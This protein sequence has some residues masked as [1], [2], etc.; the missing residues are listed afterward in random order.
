MRVTSIIS[1][2]A[3]SLLA[4]GA[5][6][7]G[8]RGWRKIYEEE[9]ISVSTR[10]EAGRDMPS[11]RGQ[12]KLKAPIL[13]LLAILLDDEHSKEWAKGADE[14]SI[15]R[16]LGPHEE[17]LYARS[18]QPWPVKDRD[19]VMQ[20]TVEVIEPGEA[21]RVH[22]VCLPGERPQVHNVV[23]METCETS[24]LLRAVDASSTQ[25]DYRVH[26]DPG[27]HLPDWIVRMASK[28]IPLDTLSA[29]AKQVERTRGK[30]RD[31][32]AQWAQ[33]N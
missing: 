31:A 4:T 11:M 6:A 5:L 19:L 22:L 3:L 26:A 25:I 20:R 16:K 7:E 10:E 1:V 14:T 29:L 21:Y 32:A 12:A 13:H 2:L 9:G 33:A 18:N 15:V 23:R 8:E 27:G 28:S 24:F 17:I 30:Y